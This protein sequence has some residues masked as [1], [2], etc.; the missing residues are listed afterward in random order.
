MKTFAGRKLGRK[1]GHRSA[2]LKNMA[3]SLLQNEKIITTFPKA[4]EIARTVEKIITDAKAGGFNAH[5]QVAKAIHQEL[6]RRKLFDT[7]VPRYLSRNGGYTQVIRNG[8]RTGDA[9][10]MAVVRL[11]P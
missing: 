4:K 8:Q 1:P 2:L 6:I 3:E 9:A 5:R 10:P 7:I 11:L